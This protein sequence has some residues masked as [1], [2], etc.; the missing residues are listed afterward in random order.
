MA[1]AKTR[2]RSFFR[3]NQ[4]EVISS[5]RSVVASAKR[6]KLKGADAMKARREIE[7]A[8]WQED[9]WTLYDLVPE[10]RY[11][12]NWVGNILSRAKLVIHRNGKPL[13][14]N[15]PAFETAQSI[16]DELFGGP[17]GQV[18]MLRQLGLHFTAVGESF[19]VGWVEE[20]EQHWE[21]TSSSDLKQKGK[22]YEFDGK[23][24]PEDDT[25]IIRLWRPHPNRRRQADSP[26]RALLPVLG[27]L[28]KFDQHIAA[29]TDSRLVS[30]GVLIVPT[31]VEFGRA[32]V[33]K[34]DGAGATQSSDATSAAQ[35]LMQEF[36]EIA[37]EALANRNS[38]SALVPLV[39]QVP[40]EFVDKVKHINFW[41]EFDEKIGEMQ[42]KA[43]DRLA[44]GMDMPP[45]ILSG[46]GELN[47]WNAWQVEEASIK[48][49]IQPLL[50]VITGS[51]TKGL[52]RDILEAEGVADFAEYSMEA[53]TTDIRL[54]PNKSKEALELHDR[55]RLSNAALLRENGF[56]PES[57]APDDAE[58]KMWLLQKVA[59]GSP[60]PEMVSAALDKLGI[61]S[62]VK[63]DPTDGI[64]PDA[65]R[66]LDEHPERAPDMDEIN[67]AS[68]VAAGEA[69]VMRALE[70]AGN[71]IKTRFGLRNVTEMASELYLV[72]PDMSAADLDFL[73]E[74][75]W[76]TAPVFAERYG[77]DPEVF[78][79]ALANCTRMLLAS[80]SSLGAT[81]VRDY[82]EAAV[83][84][85]LV[86]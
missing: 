14:K 76:T 26:A 58:R 39:L 40:G 80:R 3:A 8:R 33:P 50:E 61:V 43:R 6:I 52:L 38:A 70:R 59:L 86:A 73:L 13:E 56:D 81:T 41:S 49:H 84:R 1:E 47:H 44:I 9:V 68:L 57:D 15:D 71:R 4:S 53:D 18:E 46:V 37:E 67:Q 85:K 35:D 69:L 60:T 83:V 20:D 7:A 55:G 42:L 5:P 51:V 11:G 66:N 28:H 75:S 62:G 17:E 21:V 30:A 54:R 36:V 45:E 2:G 23:E 34:D 72:A 77:A 32:N 25:V 65:P 29:Q 63:V 31:E 24:L 22:G 74:D 19:I 48:A 16:L 78:T 27:Q 10:F 79:A 12:C 64:R 82:L